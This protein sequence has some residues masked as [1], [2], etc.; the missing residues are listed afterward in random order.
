MINNEQVAYKAIQ[1]C[2][3]KYHFISTC[4][5]TDV[6][7]HGRLLVDIRKKTVMMMMIKIII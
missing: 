5:Q 7:S 3:H 2:H 1:A 6:S 4:M